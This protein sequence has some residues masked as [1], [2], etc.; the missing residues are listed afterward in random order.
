MTS[1]KYGFIQFH[2]LF[3]CCGIALKVSTLNDL[4]FFVTD[5][6]GISFYVATA[7][8]EKLHND[9]LILNSNWFEWTFDLSTVLACG[10][11]FRLLAVDEIG[12]EWYSNTLM[13]DVNTENDTVLVQYWCNEPAFGIEYDGN[14]F[15]VVRLPAILTEPN[16]KK[17][18]SIYEDANGKRTVL[19]RELRKRYKFQTDYL[20]EEIHDK[21]SVMFAHDHVLINGKEVDEDGTYTVDWDN[22][23]TSD[24]V[25]L[26]MG[27][28]TVVENF[29][30]R[31]TNC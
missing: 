16:K 6:N 23:D 2:E 22:I 4:K 13:Y 18:E 26:A 8:G 10:D 30:S 9:P 14:K 29:V 11:C 24:C 31:N 3:E 28:T 27:E 20:S 12:K 1:S 15:C 21:I 5:G 25:D 7:Y 19:Y 17:E